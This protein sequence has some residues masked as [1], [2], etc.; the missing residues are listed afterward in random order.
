MTPDMT[1]TYVWTA[2]FVAAACLFWGV[3]F[4]A[5]VRG[6]RDVIDI[7]ISEREKHRARSS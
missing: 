6:G 1:L 4:W 5:V 3:A 7:I 2:I